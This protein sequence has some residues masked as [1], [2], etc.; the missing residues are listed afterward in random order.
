V[1]C[2]DNQLTHL[3]FYFNATMP[4]NPIKRHLIDLE[5]RKSCIEAKIGSSQ[6]EVDEINESIRIIKQ[7]DTEAGVKT[8]PMQITRHS[9][10]SAVVEIP[11]AVISQDCSNTSLNKQMQKVIQELFGLTEY[12]EMSIKFHFK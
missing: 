4:I 11:L 10:N 9:K 6:K 1:E 7:L 8:F 2:D 5:S 12:G 3:V